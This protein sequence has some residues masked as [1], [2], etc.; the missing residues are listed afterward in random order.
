M[1]LSDIFKFED[2]M[3]TYSDEDIPTL[4]DSIYWR[5]PGLNWT[6]I[7]IDIFIILCDNISS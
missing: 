3:A 1:D 5:D 6:F 7:Y 2:L 4:K